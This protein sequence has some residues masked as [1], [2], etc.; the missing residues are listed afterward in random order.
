MFA[1]SSKS[2]RTVEAAVSK[3]RQALSMVKDTGAIVWN[4]YWRRVPD[5]V[6]VIDGMQHLETRRI[7]ETHLAACLRG[8]S[9]DCVSSSEAVDASQYVSRY[10]DEVW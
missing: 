7:P 4:D 5:V 10:P 9:R 2:G 1:R 6:R 8:E 3:I